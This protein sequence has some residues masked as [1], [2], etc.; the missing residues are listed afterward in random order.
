[1]SGRALC[2]LWRRWC[3][4]RRRALLWGRAAWC[5]RGRRPAREPAAPRASGSARR[6]EARPGPAA[7]HGHRSPAR[8][9]RRPRTPQPGPPALLRLHTS[10][11]WCATCC[12]ARWC[13][14]R[15]GP[16]AAHGHRSPALRPSGAST[17]AVRL[18]LLCVAPSCLLLSN[19][20]RNS[21][22]TIS[23][24]ELA[25]LELERFWAVFKSDRGKLRADLVLP[26]PCCRPRAP[27]PGRCGYCASSTF[28]CNSPVT[29]SVFELASLEL[30]RFWALLKVHA[31]ELHAEFLVCV[32]VVTRGQWSLVQR[33]PRMLRIRIGCCYLDRL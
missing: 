3:S 16:A 11:A 23:V 2:C 14:S 7:A 29:I 8:P 33:L 5:A 21:P 9:R 32:T 22:V 20:A 4:G 1:M 31:I 18:V 15:P 25:S 24:F 6:L 17:P 26:R 10:D 19:F 30:Q 13:D 12:L 28:A 27:Q